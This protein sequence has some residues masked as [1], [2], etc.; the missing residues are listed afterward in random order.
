M[1]NQL[2]TSSCWSVLAVFNPSL[3]AAVTSIGLGLVIVFSLHGSSAESAAKHGIGPVE[4]IVIGL[5]AV[6]IAFVLKTGRDRSFQERRRTK[7][8]AK[9]S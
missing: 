7:K 9:S 8:D 5:L 6:V 3:L 2:V 4:D 1:N